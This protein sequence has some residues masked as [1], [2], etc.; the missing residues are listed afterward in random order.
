MDLKSHRVT[1]VPGSSGLFSPRWSPTGKYLLATRADSSAFL[2]FDLA[3]QKWSVLVQGVVGYPYWS[4]DGSYVYFEDVAVPHR[5]SVARIRIK[6]G[7]V[8]TIA[9]LSALRQ[10]S[11][12]WIGR[13]PDDLPIAVREIGTEEIYALDW[14]AH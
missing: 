12:G 4:R 6:D 13:G 1:T 10:I 14:I 9:D 5:S 2:L 11:V 7:S 3:H 8:E